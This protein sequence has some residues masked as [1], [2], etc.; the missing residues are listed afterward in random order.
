V[1]KRHNTHYISKIYLFIIC[2]EYMYHFLH[3]TIN[4]YKSGSTNKESLIAGERE[5]FSMARDATLAL[6]GMIDKRSKY[7]FIV[8]SEDIQ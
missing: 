1:D 8:H 5:A 4:K 2:F 6:F 3:Y 7:V